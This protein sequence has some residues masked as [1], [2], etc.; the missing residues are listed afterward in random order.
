MRRRSYRHTT[1]GDTKMY[2]PFFRQ[3]TRADGFRAVAD[4]R[5]GADTGGEGQWVRGRREEAAVCVQEEEGS[6]WS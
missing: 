3:A 6:Y 2:V 1:N 5:L 4:Q